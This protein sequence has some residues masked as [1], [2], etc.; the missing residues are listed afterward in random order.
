[1]H[2][3]MNVLR[4]SQPGDELIVYRFKKDG[5]VSMAKPCKDC[6]RMI[7]AKGIKKVTYTDWEGNLHIYKPGRLK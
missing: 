6:R 4:F 7:I 2:A 1:M 3:E 5:S